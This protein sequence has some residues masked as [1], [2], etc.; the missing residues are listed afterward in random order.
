MDITAQQNPTGEEARES[1]SSQERIQA[2]VCALRTLLEGDDEE[3]RETFAYLK[4]VLDEDRFSTRR[5][6]P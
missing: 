3:Q 1:A 5:L 6:F 2:T 4:Q